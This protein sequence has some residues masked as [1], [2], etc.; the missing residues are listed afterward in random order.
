M[1]NGNRDQAQEQLPRS[2]LDRVAEY[3]DAQLE[4]QRLLV[5]KKSIDDQCAIAQDRC[6]QLWNG[7]RSS[8]ASGLYVVEDR[9]VNV[10]GL[11]DWPPPVM[12]IKAQR[13]TQ[14]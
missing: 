14:G 11:S 1:S 9:A 10:D 5:A 2:S 7:L 6:R 4:Y 12:S 8:I 3:M 13:Q